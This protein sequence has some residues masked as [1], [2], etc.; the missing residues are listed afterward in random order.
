[1]NYALRPL[2]HFPEADHGQHL[3]VADNFVAGALFGGFASRDL[4]F[5][6]QDAFPKSLQSIWTY[7]FY[8]AF[9][10]LAIG[11]SSGN[12][13]FLQDFPGV[14]VLPGVNADF[15]DAGVYAGGVWNVKNPEDYSGPF[16]CVSGAVV[17]R[18]AGISVPG[19]H[20]L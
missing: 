18:F 13:G 19:C 12:D 7:G 9:Y 14:N 5:S 6:L 8:G 17:A 20:C 1:M 4:G 15:L 10:T 16:E 2:P 11:S 3:A